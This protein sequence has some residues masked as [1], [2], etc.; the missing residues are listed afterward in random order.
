MELEIA[1]LSRVGSRARNEDA[2]GW[3]TGS[4][5]SFCVVSD[6]AGGHRGGEVA[7]KLI[8][9]ETR[10]WF[11]EHSEC[12]GRAIE[13]A[14]RHANEVLVREQKNNADIDDM[15]ATAVVL[16]VDSVARCAAWGHL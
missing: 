14:L 3:W 4:G 7:S 10:L 1:A 5:T 12:S 6:G 16:A 15:R 8:V 13:A 11:R 2:C 9:S